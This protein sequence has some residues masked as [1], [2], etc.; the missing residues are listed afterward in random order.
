MR[1]NLNRLYVGPS[2]H[3][4]RD[5]YAVAALACLLRWWTS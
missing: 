3:R 4:L 2:T 5:I 1:T